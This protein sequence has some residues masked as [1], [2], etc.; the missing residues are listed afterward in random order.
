[1]QKVFTKP[2]RY[3]TRST[4]RGKANDDARVMGKLN[5]VP[6]STPITDQANDTRV[7]LDTAETES[8]L[9]TEIQK[10]MSVT[11]S[12]AVSNYNEAFTLLKEN[13]PEQRLDIQ[14][15]YEK[16]R[17]LDNAFSELKSEADISEDQR[18]VARQCCPNITNSVLEEPN[19]LNVSNCSY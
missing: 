3:A 10:E 17:Q 5:T 12:Q 19:L 16:F 1:M 7:K 2:V 18:Y 8:T 13:S 14:L 11:E 4:V 6:D 9:L 15:A